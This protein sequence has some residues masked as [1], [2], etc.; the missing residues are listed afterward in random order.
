LSSGTRYLFVVRARDQ[1]GNKSIPS[2]VMFKTTG[3]SSEPEPLA[4]CVTITPNTSTSALLQWTFEDGEKNIAGVRI[5]VNGE[6]H[7]DVVLPFKSK[8]LKDLVPGVKYT[9]TVIA[10]TLFVTQLSEPTAVV[11]EPQNVLTTC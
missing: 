3:P 10:Y 5:T 1:A 8:L 2:E 6:Y 11:Y 9:I 7:S 4:P